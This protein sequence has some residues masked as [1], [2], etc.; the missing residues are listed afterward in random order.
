MFSEKL[1][2]RFFFAAFFLAGAFFFAAFFLAGAFFF[3]TFFVVAFFLAGAFF[4][5]FFAVA[6]RITPFQNLFNVIVSSHIDL[7][8]S[9]FAISFVVSYA[10]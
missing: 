9:C 2:Y 8:S 5:F 4:F 10:F 7:S 6:N 3:A 1:L